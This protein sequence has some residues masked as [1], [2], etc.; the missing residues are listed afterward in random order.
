MEIVA[1]AVATA[2]SI[3][4][5]MCVVRATCVVLPKSVWRVTHNVSENVREHKLFFAFERIN[6]HHDRLGTISSFVPLPQH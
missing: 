1:T 6:I 4:T 2:T 3:I 5:A